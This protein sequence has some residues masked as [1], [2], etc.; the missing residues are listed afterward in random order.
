MREGRHTN[1]TFTCRHTDGAA[2]GCLWMRR[3]RQY[4]ATLDANG[5]YDMRLA[6]LNTMF[7]AISQE[8]TTQGVALGAP[9]ASEADCTA[10]CDCSVDAV[11]KLEGRASAPELTAP[12]H[13]YCDPNFDSTDELPVEEA[14]GDDEPDYDEFYLAYIYHCDEVGHEITH[15]DADAETECRHTCNCLADTIGQYSSPDD[16][17]DFREACLGPC[18]SANT[19][20]S[21]V[22]SEQ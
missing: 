19:G 13:D 11:R 3:Q 7:A 16:A 6:E 14:D 4:A 2:L 17:D 20:G 22:R 10:L 21:M 8:C 5:A 15:V 9:P 18:A 12:C 1:G